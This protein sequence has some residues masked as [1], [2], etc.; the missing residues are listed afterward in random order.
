MRRGGPAGGPAHHH[1]LNTD[2]QDGDDGVDDNIDERSECSN[3]KV[4][5]PDLT[6]SKSNLTSSLQLDE[7]S[8][9]KKILPGINFFW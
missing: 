2:D 1:H 8:F 6:F 3:G 4:G 9:R 7:Q 5:F